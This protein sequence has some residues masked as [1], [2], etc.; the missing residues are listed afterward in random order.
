MALW[1]SSFMARGLAAASLVT[2]VLSFVEPV[3][4]QDIA[5][6]ANPTPALQ[7]KIDAVAYSPEE[8]ANI[9]STIAFLNDDARP[10]PNWRT[11]DSKVGRTSMDGLLRAYGGPPREAYSV[12]SISDRTDTIDDIMAKGDRVWVRYTTRSRHTGDWFGVP[13]T[14]K[15]VTYS[16]QAMFRFR[17]SK[18]AE[19][20]FTVDESAVLEQLGIPIG[21]PKK[22]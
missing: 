21:F 16:V 22:P 9:K 17:D 6:P 19:S 11:P 12:K 20:D 10:R 15:F 2:A 4:A 7:T 13:P 8:L 14:G 18:I 5:K 3:M 1:V